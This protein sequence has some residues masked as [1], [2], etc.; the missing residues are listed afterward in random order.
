MFATK[1][2]KILPVPDWKKWKKKKNQTK[3]IDVSITRNFSNQQESTVGLSCLLLFD[4]IA[5]SL[6]LLDLELWFGQYVGSKRDT[7]K[8]N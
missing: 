4:L 8:K 5:W 1:H 6:V 3:E 2:G 7:K